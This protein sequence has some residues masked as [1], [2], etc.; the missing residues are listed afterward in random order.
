MD[1]IIQPTSCCEIYRLIDV[2]RKRFSFDLC[3]SIYGHDK[4][5]L[6]A[7]NGYFILKE[8]TYIE[9]APKRYKNS[10]IRYHRLHHHRL[11]CY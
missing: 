2:D 10:F 11:C 6:Y 8:P 5:I 1:N 7:F 4:L 3:R 9:Y